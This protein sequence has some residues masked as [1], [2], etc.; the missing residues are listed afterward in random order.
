MLVKMCAKVGIKATAFTV[1]KIKVKMAIYRDL[2]SKKKQDNNNYL[3][4]F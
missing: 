1:M 2:S 3:T 4:V